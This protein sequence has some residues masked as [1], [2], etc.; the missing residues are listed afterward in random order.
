[1]IQHTIHKL[2]ACYAKNR[3]VSTITLVVFTFCVLSACFT[4][5]E[6]ETLISDT[7]QLYKRP[8]ALMSYLS[9][10]GV[11]GIAQSHWF[12]QA[13]HKLALSWIRHVPDKDR[14]QYDMVLLV[15]DPY[16]LLNAKAIALLR[17]VGWILIK[18]DPL[19]GIPS[20]SLYLFQNHYTHTAQ[21]TKLRLWTFDRY[22]HIIYLDSDML[23]VKDFLGAIFGYTPSFNTLGVFGTN[24][25]ENF[26]AGFLYITP[27][28]VEFIQMKQNASSMNYDTKLQE[29]AF[30][31]VYWKNRTAYMPSNVNQCLEVITDSCIVIH[32]IGTNKP[33]FACSYFTLFQEAC[34]EWNSYNEPML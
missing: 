30:L 31:N 3:G 10:M 9:I 33:W 6:K 8:Y 15:T 17:N 12:V 34:N 2:K 27:S 19:Y 22:R 13:A 32:F 23:I 4:W 14:I 28:K 16:C 24:S 5:S 11:E 25:S 26:N 1:M 18:V 21:F 20:D 29:Q 7:D